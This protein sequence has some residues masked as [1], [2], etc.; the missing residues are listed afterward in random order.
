MRV[1]VVLSMV[2]LAAA[3]AKAEAAT[4]VLQRPLKLTQPNMSH[5]EMLPAGTELTLLSSKS[6]WSR[7]QSGGQTYIGSTSQYTTACQASAAAPVVVAAAAA[8]VAVAPV[9]VAAVVAAPVVAAAV[10]AAAPVAAVAA[11]VA[12]VVAA[13]VAAVGT[14]AKAKAEPLSLAPSSTSPTPGQLFVLGL[15]LLGVV[16]AGVLLRRRTVVEQQHLAVVASRTLG[17]GKQLIVVDA[18]DSRLLLGVTEQ[19]ITLLSST[20]TH[21]APRTSQAPMPSPAFSL[22]T[23]EQEATMASKTGLLQDLGAKVGGLWGRP[24][25]TKTAADWGDFDRI[26][27]STI[28]D[29]PN[30][31]APPTNHR[32]SAERKSTPVNGSG[33][34]AELSRE[35]QRHGARRSA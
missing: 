12:A 23:E 15:L 1:L 4:C 8:P 11:P 26:L 27:A 7:V 6:G 16:G 14:D 24:A 25:P 29:T 22:F 28:P 35:L 3:E 32:R 10:A 13:P 2:V 19:G 33:D 18:G 34:L 17:R 31:D 30:T 20:A 5:W 9:A 21:H